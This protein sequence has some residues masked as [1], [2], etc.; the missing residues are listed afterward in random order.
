MGDDIQF[1]KGVGPSAAQILA[2]MNLRT[3]GDLLRHIPRRYED[4]TNFRRI[5]DLIPGEAATIQANTSAVR[6]KAGQTKAA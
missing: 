4:R 6:P 2:Q 5:H 3:V 1:V